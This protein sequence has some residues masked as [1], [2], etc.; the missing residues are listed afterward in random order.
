MM[1]EPIL[2][3][4]ARMGGAAGPMNTMGPAVCASASGSAGTSL[5]WPQPAHTASTPQRSATST[6][7]ATLA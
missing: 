3:P 1:V 6:M 2:S 5:A 7:S 4:S